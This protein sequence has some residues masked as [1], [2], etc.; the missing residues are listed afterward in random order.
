MDTDSASW[1]SEGR[2]SRGGSQS[3]G[4]AVAAPYTALW[5]CP[6]V[7]TRTPRLTPVT[8]PGHTVETWLHLGGAACVL[9]L[10]RLCVRPQGADGMYVARG[11]PPPR[12][13]RVLAGDVVPRFRMP[14]PPGDRVT[15]NGKECVCQRCSLPASVSSSVHLTQGLW[16]KW[17]AAGRGAPRC[18]GRGLTTLRPKAGA[19]RTNHCGLA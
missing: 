3:S 7:R 9:G 11:S 5:F 16:S 15:F 19:A 1:G 10:W 6:L 2:G 18:S 13:A 12:G 17:G 4:L 8:S 14:F